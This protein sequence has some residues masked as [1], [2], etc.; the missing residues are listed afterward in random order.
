MNS[1]QS[2]IPLTVKIHDER[3]DESFFVNAPFYEQMLFENFVAKG[4]RLVC[5]EK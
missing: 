5:F 2:P 3:R 4:D 1:P